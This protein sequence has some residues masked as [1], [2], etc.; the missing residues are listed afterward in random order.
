MDSGKHGSRTLPRIR[1]SAANQAHVSL[2]DRKARENF[3]NV[4]VCTDPP[5]FLNLGPRSDL[6]DLFTLFP[7]DME[8]MLSFLGV[9]YDSRPFIL[10]NQPRSVLSA[11]VSEQSVFV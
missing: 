2:G 6:S 11:R 9:V 3:P 8:P 7:Q 1:C 10:A 5:L 4:I